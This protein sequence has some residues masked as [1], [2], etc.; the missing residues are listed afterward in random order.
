VDQ[1]QLQA[2]LFALARELLAGV[3]A[4]Q[5]GPVQVV[6]DNGTVRVRLRQ[7]SPGP[8]AVGPWLDP[9]AA[10][11][12]QLLRESLLTD[13]ERETLLVLAGGPLSARTL[14]RRI[15][16]GLT[17]AKLRFAGLVD[18]GILRPGPRGYVITQP[19]FLAIARANRS[20]T[21]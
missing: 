1:R 11:Q 20:P 8:T 12:L 19:L 7:E 5:S 21:P 13:Q 15:G 17:S 16:V 4:A 18:R 9:G 2:L 3:D 10:Q 14:A 6:L